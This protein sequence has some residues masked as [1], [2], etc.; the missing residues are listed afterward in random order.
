M[1]VVAASVFYQT[2]KEIPTP[3]KKTQSDLALTSKAIDALALP[4]EAMIREKMY[5][6]GKLENAK[7][8]K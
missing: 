5:A 6:E 8:E 3:P 7:S 4:K 2:M 1:Q